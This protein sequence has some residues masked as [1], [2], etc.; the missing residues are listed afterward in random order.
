MCS[1]EIIVNSITNSEVECEIEIF[2]PYS[3]YLTL[4][5]SSLFP[6]PCVFVKAKITETESEKTNELKAF[7]KKIVAECRVKHHINVGING[8]YGRFLKFSLKH[9]EKNEINNYFSR[10]LD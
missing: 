9:I 4:G 5:F 2:V 1:T 8:I 6:G 7:V 3:T 10:I